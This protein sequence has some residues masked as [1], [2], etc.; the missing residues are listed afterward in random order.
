MKNWLKNVMGLKAKL[1]FGFLAILVTGLTAAQL[2]ELSPSVQQQHRRDCSQFAKSFAIAGSVMLS[3]GDNRD[4]KA[5]VKQWASDIE[6]STDGKAFSQPIIRSIGVRRH[7]GKLLA[8]SNE[9]ESV[10]GDNLVNAIDPSVLRFIVS[11]VPAP[12]FSIAEKFRGRGTGSTS[13]G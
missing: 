13:V 8:S 3:D 9:H 2:L 11:V 6:R 1:A 10:W 4:L 5:L 12:G 7:T